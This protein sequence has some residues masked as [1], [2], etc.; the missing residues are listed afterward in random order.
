MNFHNGMQVEVCCDDEGFHGAWFP[1]TVIGNLTNAHR[2][3]FIIEYDYFATNEQTQDTFVEEI[4]A[5]YIR[6]TP[7]IISL[8]QNIPLDMFVDVFDSGCWWTGVVVE[9]FESP[10]S[11]Q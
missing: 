11:Q 8:P 7:P 5:E 3:M 1:A 4:F 6:P 10:L 2:P 9:E